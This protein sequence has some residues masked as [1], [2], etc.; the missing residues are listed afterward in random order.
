MNRYKFTLS[1]VITIK[2]DRK[3][4]LYIGNPFVSYP[5]HLSTKTQTKKRKPIRAT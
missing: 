3:Q 5:L 4:L 2:R 1:Q